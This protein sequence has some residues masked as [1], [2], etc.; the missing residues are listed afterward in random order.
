MSKPDEF[1]LP[2][3]PIDK[4]KATK[5]RYMGSEKGKE[6]LLRYRTSDKGKAAQEKYQKS[7]RGKVA[8]YRYQM[9]EKYRETSKRQNT[10]KRLLTQI[11][12]FLEENPGKTIADFNQSTSQDS[13]GG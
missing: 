6:V 12:K 10:Q 1:V 8:Q 3:D 2:K 5:K 4:M 9:S 7:E 11:S 13:A